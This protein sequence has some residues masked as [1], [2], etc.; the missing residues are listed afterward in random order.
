V[1][2]LLAA[3]ADPNVQDQMGLS[4]LMVASISGEA[5][6]VRVLMQGGARADLLEDHGYTA[7]ALAQLHRQHLVVKLLKQ[8]PAGERGRKQR[9]GRQSSS[10]SSSS[11]TAF[12]SLAAPLRAIANL[13]RRGA[14]DEAD[15]KAQTPTLTPTPNPDPNPNPNPNQ[16]DAKAEA[17]A[18]IATQIAAYQRYQRSSS[19]L[20]PSRSR[21]TLSGRAGAGAEAGRGVA[22]SSTVHDGLTPTPTPTPTQTPTP[23][24]NPNPNPNPNQVHGG[25]AFTGCSSHADG[26]ADSFRRTRGQLQHGDVPWTVHDGRFFAHHVRAHPQPAPEPASEP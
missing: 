14:K 15:A 2:R 4:A 7:L 13:A 21:T 16:A 6:C 1:R 17:D 20:Q 11:T 25:T 18:D 8:P 3:E 26:G 5:E 24:P 9:L 10:S 12:T 23:T 19:P 22:G